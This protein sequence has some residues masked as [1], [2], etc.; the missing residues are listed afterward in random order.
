M[1]IKRKVNEQYTNNKKGN[2]HA[3]RT[4]A[5][6]NKRLSERECDQ[7]QLRTISK[8]QKE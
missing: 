2:K 7:D 5:A 6:S 1:T 4:L 3:K 8:L